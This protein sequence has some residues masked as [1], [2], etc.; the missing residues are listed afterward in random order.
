MAGSIRSWQA[1]LQL[2]QET[3]LLLSQRILTTAM[4]LN[5]E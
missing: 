4:P 2:P 5:N 3:H 1:S